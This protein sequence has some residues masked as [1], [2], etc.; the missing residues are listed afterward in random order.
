MSFCPERARQELPRHLR[1]RRGLV[2]RQLADAADRLVLDALQTGELLPPRSEITSAL[3]ALDEAGIRA[4]AGWDYL[5][6]VPED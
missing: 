2:A 6:K 5:A 1:E 3:Q 4:Y